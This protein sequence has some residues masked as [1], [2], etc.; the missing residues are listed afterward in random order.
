MATHAA[1]S[2]MV[3]AHRHLLSRMEV[4]ALAGTTTAPVVTMETS[5][6]KMKNASVTAV[7]RSWLM[8]SFFYA[9]TEEPC[10]VSCLHVQVA[11]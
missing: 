7:R 2:T 1:T 11:Q 8:W 4:A 3:G 10:W 9:A 6:A 5:A